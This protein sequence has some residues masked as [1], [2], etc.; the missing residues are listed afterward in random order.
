VL[1]GEGR[2]LDST[3]GTVNFNT[4]SNIPVNCTNALRGR[5][6]RG[7]PMTLGNMRVAPSG[8]YE[9]DA[10]SFKMIP[11]RPFLLKRLRSGRIGSA[12]QIMD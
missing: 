4:T 8:S 3:L 11:N 1:V 6:S 12:S 2:E 10:G 7:P 9:G 5:A